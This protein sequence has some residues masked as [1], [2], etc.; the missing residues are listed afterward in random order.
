MYCY[1]TDQNRLTY[2]MV[3][4]GNKT[5]TSYF[6]SKKCSIFAQV[7]LTTLNAAITFLFIE[8]DD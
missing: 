3:Y 4:F 8:Q 6:L 2:L 5:K 1:K 7:F